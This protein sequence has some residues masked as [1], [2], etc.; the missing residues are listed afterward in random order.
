MFKNRL[1]TSLV[2][3][4]LLLLASSAASADEAL[5]ACNKALVR[6]LYT[7]VMIGR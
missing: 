1:A 4:V 5:T 3:T 2:L 7:T 6:D